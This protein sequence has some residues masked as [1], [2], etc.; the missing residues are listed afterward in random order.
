MT[1]SDF[2]KE[3]RGASA[4][5]SWTANQ[6]IPSPMGE[7]TVEVR[8]GLGDSAPPDNEMLRRAEELVALFRANVEIIHNKVFEHYQM[9]SESADLDR[10][11]ILGH[12][13]VR[14]L[15]VFRGGDP[16]E[17]YVSRVYIIPDWDVEHAI[18]LAH[19]DGEWEFVDS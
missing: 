6:A 9:C 3:P 2:T 15:T 19:R 8:M 7:F 11:G 12:L 13:E 10:D 16:D 18:Y 5:D 14:T 1:L 4:F 17:P